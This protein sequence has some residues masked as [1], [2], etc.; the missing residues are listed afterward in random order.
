MEYKGYNIHKNFKT[1]YESN[2][3]SGHSW[4]V[5]TELKTF[6]ICGP[7]TFHSDKY[8]S[9]EKAKEHIDFL[10][11]FGLNI[12]RWTHDIYTRKVYIEKGSKLEKDMIESN[13]RATPKT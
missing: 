2:P 12:P 7:M 5:Y 6:H 4:P 11:K 8:R 1:T 10:V 3:I 13:K 9:I